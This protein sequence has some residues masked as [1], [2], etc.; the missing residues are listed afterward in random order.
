LL[1]H[2]L[3]SILF[4]LLLLLIQGLV[5]W[6]QLLTFLPLELID[7]FLGTTTSGSYYS[8]N[9]P[10]PGIVDIILRPTGFTYI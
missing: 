5:S 9:P 8:P 4:P 2:K 3:L 10:L 1:N 6:M 7:I